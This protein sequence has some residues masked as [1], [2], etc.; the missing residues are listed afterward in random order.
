VQLVYAH[1]VEG[2]FYKALRARITPG[3]KG[4][5]KPLGLDLD[6]SPADMPR[7]KWAEA[8]RLAATEIFPKPHEDES[9]RL[10][11]RALI[12]GFSGTLIGK[13]VIGVLRLL[14]PARSIH[15]LEKTL[16]SGNNYIQARIEQK[17]PTEFDGWINECNGSPG[18]VI[19]VLEGALEAAGAKDVKIT[20][21]KYDGH[22]AELHIVWRE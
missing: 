14:G 5:L 17:G 7:E 8:L 19:G 22:A 20:A 3:L 11:G 16:Q 6:A 4:R 2:L 10:L 12:E 13:S 21:S 18:Y 15:R 9:F 1:T